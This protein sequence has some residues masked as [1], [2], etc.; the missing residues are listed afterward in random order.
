VCEATRPAST[1]PDPDVAR[2]RNLGPRSA[3]MLRAI[4]VTHRSDL[5]ALGAVA[6]YLAVRRQQQVSLNL[7]YALHAALLDQDWRALD[8]PTRRRL[9]DEVGAR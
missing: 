9:R 8:A 6:V 4:G 2:L 3:E 5:E 7:L 1:D